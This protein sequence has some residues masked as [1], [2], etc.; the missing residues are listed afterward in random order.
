MF[1]VVKNLG[2]FG[3]DV[4]NNDGTSGESIYGMVFRDENYTISHDS[5]YLLSA[6]KPANTPHTSN[7]QFMI[8]LS[9]VV[10][11]DFRYQVFGRVNANSRALVDYIEFFAGTQDWDKVEAPFYVVQVKNCYLT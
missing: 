11:L 2:I 3:G 8:T 9:P 1:R 10:W 7:S 4:V 6:T 5:R